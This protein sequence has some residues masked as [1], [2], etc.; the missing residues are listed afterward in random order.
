[1]LFNEAKECLGFRI[2]DDLWAG[3]SDTG[4]QFLDTTPYRDKSPG[5][6]VS[7]WNSVCRASFYV[8]D[9]AMYEARLTWVCEMQECV[10]EN[11]K[12]VEDS[13]HW[14]AS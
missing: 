13:W 7:V 5:G 8:Y 3:P 4:I 6:Q 11:R 2:E 14:L 1:M 10:W 12:E 9:K